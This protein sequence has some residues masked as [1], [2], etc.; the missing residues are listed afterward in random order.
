MIFEE[1][2]LQIV[3]GNW[4]L[5]KPFNQT[6]SLKMKTLHEKIKT[7]KTPSKGFFLV[8]FLSKHT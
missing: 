1:V 5:Y 2:I 3:R 6:R 4:C 7:K 8:L